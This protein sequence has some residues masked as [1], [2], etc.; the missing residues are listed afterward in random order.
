MEIK[1]THFIQY[2][3]EISLGF[4]KSYLKLTRYVIFLR[5]KLQIV[6]MFS[7]YL[8]QRNEHVS[9]FVFS[10][11]IHICILSYISKINIPTTLYTKRMNS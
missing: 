4:W 7:Q 9:A 10:Y 5:L 8:I 3:Q 1:N 6:L 11:C 2:Y